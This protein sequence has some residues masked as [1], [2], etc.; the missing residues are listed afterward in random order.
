M[1]EFL[2]TQQA[3]LNAEVAKMMNSL[4]ISSSQGINPLAAIF[5]ATNMTGQAGRDGVKDGLRKSLKVEPEYVVPENQ[6]ENQPE[7]EDER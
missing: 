5:A 7:N 2:T 3:A 6:P 1:L 4:V